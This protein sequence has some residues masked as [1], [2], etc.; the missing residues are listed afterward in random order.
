M[1]H[2]IP[3]AVRQRMEVLEAWDQHDRQDGTPR[4]QRLRQIPPETGKFLAILA[5]GAPAGTVVEI[6]TSAGYSSLWL[7]LA[8]RLR[9]DRLVT[10]EIQAEKI[11]LA[12]QTLKEAQLESLVELVHA[13]ARMHLPN[14]PQIAFCFLDAEKEV[15]RDCYELVVPR[16][17]PGG[18][19]VADNFLSHRQELQPVV[20]YALGDRR[21]DGLVVPVGKGLLLCRK[22]T[23]TMS[24]Y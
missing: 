8:C 21:V 6:G 22:H 7:A 20:E 14:F 13:D 5:A 1:F 16:L 11:M 3:L 9:R 2:D 18:L 4:L 17:V 24:T 12:R 19:L 10:F 23:Q 15:Y